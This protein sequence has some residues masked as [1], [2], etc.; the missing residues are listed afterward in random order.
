MNK[1]ILRLCALMILSFLGILTLLHGKAKTELYISGQNGILL[2][3]DANGR[4]T[5]FYPYEN[6]IDGLTYFFLP[7]YME[8]H[9]IYMKKSFGETLLV[10]G[11]PVKDNHKLEWKNDEIYQIAVTGNP[12]CPP[13]EYQVVFMKSANIPSIFIDTQ[14]GS[15][16][17]VHADKENKESG[18]ICIIES[19]GS[20]EYSGRLESI[21]GRGNSTWGYDKKPYSIKLRNEKALLGMDQGKKWYLLPIFIEKNRMNSKVALDIAT[22]LGLAFTSQC[23][24]I[25]LYL[26][27]E[28]RGNYLLCE[29]VTVGDG[30]IAIHDL[31]TENMAN[32]PD[33]DEAPVFMYDT[34]KGCVLADGGNVNGG[35]LIEKDGP[36]N[37]E[38]EKSGFLTTSGACF[39][40]KSPEHASQEQVEYIMDYFQTIE[41]M[42]TENTPD[43]QNYIDLDS[44]AARFLVDEI[45]LNYDVNVTSTFFYKNIDSNL[46]YAGPVWDYDSSMGFG[47]ENMHEWCDYERFTFDNVREGINTL[48]W[49]QLLY[50][51]ETFYERM[52]AK[53]ADLLPYMETLLEST[54]DEYAEYIRASALM[55][56]KRWQY[57]YA[58]S[59]NQGHYVEFDSNVRYLKYYLAKRLNY[60][61]EAW[62]IPYQ[63]FT[64][65]GNGEMHSVSFMV[66]DTCVETRMVP[67]GETMPNVP[68]LPDE[69]KYLGW[70]FTF[71]EERYF[72]KLP[73]YEDCV[74]YAKELETTP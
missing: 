49:Y 11:E 58:T 10:N 64:T 9:V 65:A 39:V 72:D 53:F 48:N 60:L 25:D 71:N 23:T 47:K 3:I 32:N 15:M 51:N 45:T 73:I 12:N 22:R 36:G 14:S 30:R 13:A 37:Y 67:D 5:E 74:L 43:Y 4:E 44:F 46:L 70:Y 59:T 21:S 33:I 20:L 69:E 66:G 54:I 31:E 56:G 29:S 57:A 26:N 7:S 1:K 68:P 62:Q 6:P 19:D 2:T 63:K 55:D 8:D 42:I 17:Y 41:N 52:T 61:C 16:E 34:Y 28:Y 27:G 50:N 18:Q 24:W 38:L 35:Y 40:L